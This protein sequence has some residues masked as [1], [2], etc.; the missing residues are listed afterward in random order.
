MTFWGKWGSHSVGLDIGS[1]GL[2]LIQLKRHGKR[3]ELTHLGTVPLASGTVVDGDI[4]DAFTLEQTLKDLFSKQKGLSKEISLA[5][6]GS[7]VLTKRITLPK[8]SEHELDNQLSI[9]GAQYIPFP[10][11]E[12][13]L[14]YQLL[15]QPDREDQKM[16]VILVAA[17]KKMVESLVR[18]IEAADL[19]PVSVETTASAL[20]TVFSYTLP[21]EET[22]ALLHLGAN[23]SLLT[24]I[25]Q[26]IPVFQRSF[27]LG[28]NT[29][30]ETLQDRLKMK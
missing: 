23:S 19:K 30:T 16:D 28:G 2:K 18:V 22:G 17:K 25:K 14:D 26:G 1:Y 10:I 24:L 8:M 20:G 4:L 13:Q 12:I 11:D 29:I 9:I 6:S 15:P 7:G 21:E 5:L 3:Y 27:M